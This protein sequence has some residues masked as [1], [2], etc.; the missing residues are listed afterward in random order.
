MIE[1]SETDF[2]ACLLAHGWHSGMENPTSYWWTVDLWF[3]KVW[4]ERYIKSQDLLDNTGQMEFKLQ[5][6]SWIRQLKNH[7]NHAGNHPYISVR[8]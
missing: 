1:Y 3:R 4:P 2:H 7:K 6:F 5:Y 8:P